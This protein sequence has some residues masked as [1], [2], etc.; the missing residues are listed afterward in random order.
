M[1]LKLLAATL[2]LAAF[3][4]VPSKS[5][6]GVPPAPAVDVPSDLD[7]SVEVDSSSLSTGTLRFAL[8]TKGSGNV[9]RVL[10]FLDG[11]EVA[12]AKDTGGSFAVRLWEITDGEHEMKVRVLTTDKKQIEKSQKVVLAVPSVKV[13]ESQF[14]SELYA[15]Q[16]FRAEVRVEGKATAARL[17]LTNFAKDFPADTIKVTTLEGGGFAFEG[18]VPSDLV[19]T[20]KTELA[21]VLLT[22]EGGKQSVAEF[23]MFFASAKSLPLESDVAQVER[24]NLPQPSSPEPQ[25]KVTFA[26]PDNALIT[27]STLELPIQ[28][29]GNIEPGTQVLLA[30]D[31]MAGYLVYDAAAL[32]GAPSSGSLTTFDANAAQLSLPVSLPTGSLKEGEKANWKAKVALRD[33]SGKV[34]GHATASLNAAAAK[35]GGL[36][37]TLSW[38]SETDV[39][40]HVVE[41]GDSEIYYGRTAS[42]QR[43][44]LDLDSNA[45]CSIDKV[46]HEN[47]Y[48]ELPPSGEYVVRVDFFDDCPPPDSPGAP[49]KGANWKVVVEGCGVKEEKIGS[50]A[51][52][53]DDQGAA[54]SG[55]EVIRFKA[56]CKPYRIS[57][58]AQYERT[59]PNGSKTKIGMSNVP[60]QVISE[61][62]L[63][64]LGKGVIGAEGVY[65][66]MFEAPENN[67]EAGLR[68][69][70]ENERVVVN[71]RDSNSV[72]RI[73]PKVTWKP[74]EQRDFKRDLVVKIE[75]DSGAIN[76][77]KNILLGMGWF[78]S[79]NLKLD[80]TRVEWERNSE[81][82]RG[83]SSYSSIEDFLS[84]EGATADSDEFDDPVILHELGHRVLTKFARDDSEGGV[85]KSNERT[86]PEMAWSEGF[87]T[88]AALRILDINMYYDT[89]QSGLRGYFIDD[90]LGQPLSTEDNTSK[91]KISEAVV[92]A[93]LWDFQDP[94]NKD[95]DDAFE[96][97]ESVMFRYIF[98]ALKQKENL[99][100]G[101][102][103]K[104]DLADLLGHY[105]CPLK[106]EE[107]NKL[108]ALVEKRFF[109]KWYQESD[110]CK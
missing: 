5:K 57:G 72:H 17:D 41:P 49:G 96:G 95:E 91:G 87:A 110:F 104:A 35:S 82:G 62:D 7:F 66:V 94:I 50:F 3:S 19:A 68:F 1:L 100:R 81:N 51:A 53:T 22:D 8:K 98:G 97:Y 26:Q 43:G 34:S 27:G 83:A 18:Q 67:G 88:Y 37:V 30:L 24:T 58:K 52:G 44:A 2:S 32:Q 16:A 20:Q 74:H 56:Q 15:G 103:E 76:I 31:G 65:E 45:G 73:N 69:V 86:S 80:Q 40:L 12:N 93:M 39:D 47:V 46:N 25:A 92:R 99:K 36:K 21:R 85:H 61:A 48:W 64:V 6:K 55:V 79:K 102:P 13:V 23:Q 59:L 89:T 4:C 71:H 33:S 63:T 78:A 29:E 60:I 42:P 70:L 10:V 106:D 107:R 109:L 14:P 9:E 108:V 101:T 38:D 54:G 90:V 77:F 28:F 11:V 105:G 84:I 75:E